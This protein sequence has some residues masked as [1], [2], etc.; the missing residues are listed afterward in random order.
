MA[1]DKKIRIVRKQDGVVFD[2][3]EAEAKTI[4]GYPSEFEKETIPG[5]SRAGYDTENDGTPRSRS[6]SRAAE[7]A[8]KPKAAARAKTARKTTA[9]RTAGRGEAAP[10]APSDAATSDNSKES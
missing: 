8:G 2:V 9:P 6:A 7:G 1:D 4:A 5:A 3:T 10:V